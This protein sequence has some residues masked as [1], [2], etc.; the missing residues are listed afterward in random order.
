MMSNEKL[1]LYE[2]KDSVTSISTM[3][4]VPQPLDEKS[5]FI[6]NRIFV[7]NFPDT[8]TQKDINSA[9]RPFGKIIE[10]NI[11]NSPNSTSRYGFVT[12]QSIDSADAVLGLYSRGRE[13]KVCGDVV[14]INHALFKPKKRTGTSVKSALTP[15]NCKSV[16]ML[17]GQTVMAEYVNGMA[18]F[19]PLKEEKSLVGN[20]ISTIVQKMYNDGSSVPISSTAQLPG[21]CQYPPNLLPCLPMIQYSAIRPPQ[22]LYSIPPTLPSAAQSNMQRLV[23]K[24]MPPCFTMQGSVL[25]TFPFIR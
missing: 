4:F 24:P 15:A 5:H 21:R 17:G 8:A 16:L 18:Y 23:P 6:R 20:Q 12:F 19:R 11:I 9:F 22:K 14:T 10:T 7:G 2:T 13:F 1:C 3:D 25:G